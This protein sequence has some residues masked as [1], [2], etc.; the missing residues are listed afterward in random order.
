VRRTGRLFVLS[1][2]H[3]LLDLLS[4]DPRF[5]ATTLPD[6]A[7]LGQPLSGE[8]ARHDRTVT[9]VTPTL[10]AIWELATPSAA[11]NNTLARCTSRCAEVLDAA[12]TVND[13]R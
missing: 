3:D 2:A 5:A 9:G 7:E 1:Q 10:A 12:S 8:P 13:S 11:I 6:L 4:R